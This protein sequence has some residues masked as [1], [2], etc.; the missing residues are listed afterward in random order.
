MSHHRLRLAASLLG[1]L[2]ATHTVVQAAAPVPGPAADPAPELLVHA[3]LLSGAGY[4]EISRVVEEGSPGVL[5]TVSAESGREPT[6]PRALRRDGPLDAR[7]ARVFETLTGAQLPERARDAL[8]EVDAI[9]AQRNAELG[10]PTDPPPTAGGSGKTFCPSTVVDGVFRFNC[11][12]YG[13]LNS[14]SPMKVDD[15]CIV[16]KAI[17][18]DHT[19]AIAYESFWTGKQHANYHGDVMQGHTTATTYFAAVWRYRWGT[20]YN[21]EA[22]DYSRYEFTGEDGIWDK[23]NLMGSWCSQI[24]II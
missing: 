4:I 17:V 23:P 21:A 6:A 3:A 20:L 8:I 13:P 24:I 9:R 12:F 15:V 22:G 2:A 16:T 19:Q 7:V 18:G 11:S 5:V 1:V 14:K 10:V